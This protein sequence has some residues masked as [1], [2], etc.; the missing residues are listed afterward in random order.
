MTLH[1][2]YQKFA[3]TP[4]EERKKQFNI[5]K[6]QWEWMSL[7]DIYE[8]LHE[9]ENKIRPDQ[10]RI[11]QLLNAV[12]WIWLNKKEKQNVETNY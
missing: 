2:F 12:E 9:I 11:D 7:N 3:N 4:L 6:S 10:I 8:E 5:A 1:K